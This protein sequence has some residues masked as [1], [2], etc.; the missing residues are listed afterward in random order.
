MH[1]SV[2]VEYALHCLFHLVSLPVK[3]PIGIKELASFQGV[4]E[5]YLSKIFTKLVKA[6]LIQ[7]IPGV[8][9]GY[10]LAR[11]PEQISFW[12]VVEAI[13]G[14]QPV[15]QCRNVIAK[16]VIHAGE[17]EDTSDHGESAA[18][19]RINITMLQAEEQMKQFLKEKTL[20]W[21]KETLD[22]ELA[23]EIQEKT[24]SWFLQRLG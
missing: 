24:K 22:Q 13:E 16:S 15:F 4:S 21:L 20:Q 9:G 17:M 18:H 8:K 19:C 3:K 7:S 11:R 2:G 23:P 12:D 5:S 14:K 6:G 10:E 1:Y